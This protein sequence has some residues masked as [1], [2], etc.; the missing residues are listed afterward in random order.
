MNV[1]FFCLLVTLLH[2]EIEKERSFDCTRITEACQT[3]IL[4]I[5]F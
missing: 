1:I 2:I 4:I 5:S 3:A